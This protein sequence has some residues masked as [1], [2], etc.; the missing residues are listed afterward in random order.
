MNCRI[1]RIRVT[2]AAVAIALTLLA[3][4]T[5]AQ[6]F[7]AGGQEK[8]SL[9][10]GGIVNQF[11]TNLRLDGSTGQ[12]TS[13]DL[14]GEG[15]KKTLSSFVGLGTWRVADNHRLDFTYFAASR[16]GS[17]QAERD[18]TIGNEVIPA[19]FTVSAESKAKFLWLDYRYSF[20]KSHA[21]EYAGALGFYPGKFDFNVTGTGQ[22]SG[23]SRTVSGSAS[24]TLPLP[25]IGLSGDWYLDP[26]WRIA[27][28]VQGMA[29]KIGGINGN[30]LV[31]F[32][33]TDYMLTRNLGVGVAYSY[34]K[35]SADASKSDFNG[36]FNWKASGFLMYATMKF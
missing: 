33:S 31:T 32:L 14:E 8:F 36:N 5:F 7:I 12:G 1:G 35:I 34:A 26:R 27:A 15:L 18:I 30:A 10:L 22:L 6:E 28:A 11:G 17:K 20:Y 25:V 24:T 2:R 29:A 23:S 16:T 19:G 4:L 3:P 13:V 9:S 21:A